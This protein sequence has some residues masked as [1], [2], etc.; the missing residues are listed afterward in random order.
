MKIYTIGDSYSI[1]YDKSD[2]VD[3]FYWLGAMTM[4]HVGTKLIDFS[5]VECD[6]LGCGK[7]IKSVPTDGIVLACFG[8]IDVRHHVFKQICLGREEDEII[9][10]LVNNYIEALKFNKIKYKYIG[11]P[12]IVPVRKNFESEQNPVRGS[13]VERLRYT[14]KL[15]YLLER[16]L[17]KYGIYFMNL[18]QYYCNSE[19]YLIDDDSYRDKSVHLQ[20]IKEM[21]GELQKMINYFN[22]RELLLKEYPKSLHDL[23]IKYNTNKAFYHNYCKFYDRILSS[24]RTQ[25]INMLELGIA[26]G[27][28]L[29]MW[30]DYFSNATIYGIDIDDKLLIN[31]DRI[32]TGLADQSKP[33]TIIKQIEG[34]NVKE[35]DFII[36]DGSHIVSHQQKCI[37]ALWPYVKKGGIYIIEDLHTN[38]AENFY[39]HPHLAPSIILKHIDQTP[40]VHDN[41]IEIMR[42]EK[43]FQFN[44]EI[45]DIYYFFNQPTK[46]LSCVFVK[47]V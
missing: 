29:Y 8:E 44:D 39:T 3:N 43:K 37:E 2:L 40:T 34:W 28:S 25:T 33:E 6:P 16:E 5:N 17:P 42:G 10:N 32:I 1:I 30:S 21:D 41:I 15:N 36:D 4:Y 22:S 47:K 27:S 26:T 14:L 35:F 12:S 38:I 9:F 20:H 7:E 31:K 45:D 23:G 13:D 19:G 18:Y 46:S 24:V 11:C